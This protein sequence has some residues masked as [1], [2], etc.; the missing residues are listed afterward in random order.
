[1]VIDTVRNWLQQDAKHD[2][3]DRVVFSSKANVSL[4]E[5]FMHSS[6]PLFPSATR[7]SGASFTEQPCAQQ[8]GIESMQNVIES[9]KNGNVEPEASQNGSV[10]SKSLQS[11]SVESESVRNNNV[12]SENFL[13]N[14]NAKSQNGNAES[15]SADQQPVIDEQDIVLD[16]TEPQDGSE[17][18]AKVDDDDLSTEDLLE[19]LQAIQDQNMKTFEELVQKL[20]ETDPM[21]VPQH[22]KVDM[23]P[24]MYSSSL[25]HGMAQG[26]EHHRYS[27]VLSPA[28][29]G[30][31]RSVSPSF[32]SSK[33]RS[34]SGDLI[35]NP[36]RTE[37]EV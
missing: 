22:L 2:I 24:S 10:E 21:P 26:Y 7:N 25:P 9:L 3:F 8:N 13:R 29:L 32:N 37:S 30:H 18:E 4:V 14:G 35:L 16:I 20:A 31:T 19:S 6:F 15:E 12:E 17:K 1:M 28:D 27:S 36:D 11:V 33:S 23:P 5:K 34:Q